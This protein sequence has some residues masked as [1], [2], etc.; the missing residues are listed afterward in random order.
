MALCRCLE[1]HGY[2]QGRLENYIAYASPVGYPN[3]A[4]VCGRC[5]TS[6]VIWLTASETQAYQNGQ[7]IFEGPNAFTRIRAE[8]NTLVEL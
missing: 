2:P 5:D 7:R 1:E 6:G 8:D 4:I 3:T